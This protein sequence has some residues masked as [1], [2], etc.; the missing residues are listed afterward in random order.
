MLGTQ[1]SGHIAAVGYELY[2]Q[3]LESAVRKQ[4][5]MP[6]KLSIQIDVDLPV[7]AYLPDTYVDDRRQKIDIYRRLTRLDKFEQIKEIK[8]ELRD[9]FGPLPGPA[10]RLLKLYEVK[11]EAAMWQVTEIFFEDTYL[12]FRFNSRPRFEQL[13]KARKMIR[14]VD[15]TNGLR[16]VEISRDWPRQVAGIGQIPLE[17]QL[18]HAVS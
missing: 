10:K 3:L 9:R 4:K 15:G 17:V 16:H 1:Q 5:A 18:M 14:I 13:V 8:S 12:G 7:A 6:A 2:C 11:L